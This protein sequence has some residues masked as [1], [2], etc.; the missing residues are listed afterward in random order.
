MDIEQYGP[1][2]IQEYF[3]SE[4]GLAAFVDGYRVRQEQL[5]MAQAVMS[6]LIN[7]EFLLTEVGTGVGKSFGYLIPA[8][9][10]TL[11]SGERVVVATRTKALQ[12]QLIEKDLP[13]LQ[14]LFKTSLVWAEAKGRENYLCWNKYIGILAGRR[15]LSDEET[16]F[17]GAVLSWAE[18]TKSGDRNELSL[19]SRLAR[20]WSIIGADRQTCQRDLCSFRE[21]CFRLKMLRSLEKASLIVTNHALLLSDRLVNNQILPEYR[22]LVIDEAHNLDREAFDKFSIRF[23]HAEMADALN[24][25][26]TNKGRR[27]NGYLQHIKG[28]YPN[29]TEEVN[30]AVQHVQGA[31]EMTDHFFSQLAKL[32]SKGANQGYA[33]VLDDRMQESQAFL[34]M[35]EQHREWQDQIH[36]LITHL[37]ELR[38]QLGGQPEEAEIAGLISIFQGASDNAFRIMEEDRLRSDSLLWID[39]HEGRPSSISTATVGTNEML[40]NRLFEQMESVVLVSATL[41]VNGSFEYMI[42]RLGL[43]PVEE[44]QRLNTLLE[45]SP[46]PYQKQACLLALSDMP[47]PESREFSE[48]VAA[49]LQIILEVMQGR[50]M[51][52][53]TSRQ[54]LVD[55]SEML[56][57]VV[58]RQG[59]TLLVQNEDGDFSTLLNRFIEL[60]HTVL[61][62]LDTFWEGIDLRGDLLECLVLVKLPFRP[63]SEPFSS[64][65]MRHC[66]LKK[67]NGF[68][69]FTLPDAAVR[70]KQ[71]SGRLIRSEK[72]RGVLVVLDP[73]L[74]RKQYGKVFTGSI[75]IKNR[76][77][78]KK[79]DLAE[80]IRNWLNLHPEEE[81]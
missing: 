69:N 17:L 51:V 11:Q 9:L 68:Q 28:Y 20:H 21:K 30:Q 56:R 5:H 8:V 50:T 26:T 1:E 47:E 37:G 2:K 73:R 45:D 7:S 39:Y 42:G 16:D 24:I 44:Q 29:L 74:W 13:D 35:E 75:P 34:Q 81:K 52:L 14:R 60:D 62:G 25:L 4:S 59:I 36:L 10:W 72:D 27:E 23:S 6:A 53:F 71:G 41:T 46:F 15:S 40:H 19:N 33:L 55:V 12:K 58:E 65:C 77:M 54:Q 31:R 67:L 43:E 18:N 79:A 70:F 57:P 61:M 49:A 64:A 76:L 48:Q 78:V 3:G 32:G 63:P 22:Y 38:K 66:S 80:Q